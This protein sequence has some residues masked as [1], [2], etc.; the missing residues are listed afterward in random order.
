MSHIKLQTS[1]IYNKTF[2]ITSIQE[3]DLQFTSRKEG[4]TPTPMNRTSDELKSNIP[5]H[6]LAF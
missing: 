4:H 6:T 1:T 3:E 5:T 2:A